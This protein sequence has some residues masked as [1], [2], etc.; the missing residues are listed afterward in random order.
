M[1][2]EDAKFKISRR[3]FLKGTM[4]T[5]LFVAAGC[6]QPA[7]ESTSSPEGTTV[8]ETPAPETIPTP[9]VITPPEEQ[10]YMNTCRTN[11]AHACA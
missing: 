1:K 4:A 8:G 7:V 6:S 10:V 11:C 9:E 2:R 3:S 5:G